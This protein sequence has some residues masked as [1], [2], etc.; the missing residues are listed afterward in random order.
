MSYPNH[1]TTWAA[2][3]A[4]VIGLALLPATTSAGQPQPE[5]GSAV[6]PGTTD[7]AA[8]PN[9]TLD[10]RVGYP[11]PCTDDLGVT[12]VVDFV[13]LGPHGASDGEPV[14]RCAPP[15]HAGQPFSGTGLDALLAAGI[16]PEG[17]KQNGLSFICRLEG[18][19]AADEALT[20]TGNPGYHEQCFRAPPVEAFWSYWW[21]AP[22]D[23]AWTS[24]NYGAT[25]R[26]AVPGGYEGWAFS[27]LRD[28][29]SVNPSPAVLPVTPGVVRVA[30]ADRYETAADLAG[31]TAAHPERV[32]VATGQ[33][34]PDALA[35][36]TVAGAQDVPVLLVRGDSV[37]DATRASLQALE[38]DEIVVLG[39]SSSVSDAVLADLDEL[40]PGAAVR[41][42]GP[43]RYATAT[44]LMTRYPIG[45]GDP[46]FVTTGADFPDVLAVSALA[47]HQQT[48]VLL[49][50]PTAL[51]ASARAALQAWGTRTGTVWGGPA[52][53]SD[54]VVGEL[55]DTTGGGWTRST[56]DDRYATAAAVAQRYQ[57]GVETV[58]VATGQGYPDALT[59]AAVAGSEG[60]PVLLTR[61]GSLP[62][63]T[64]AALERLDPKRIVVLGGENV[65]G[66]PVM[67]Q[68]EQYL[69]D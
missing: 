14:V 35:A 46:A 57:P 37:P 21:A 41:V 8:L 65:I 30:G 13:K 10:P 56:G 1:P 15:Q 5:H 4:A 18:R 33:D 64:A 2:T 3:G 31:R 63:A 32:F 45:T 20:L 7:A 43:N 27:Y 24:S 53:V 22:G 38:P 67:D 59:G 61:Q 29:P 58:Y 11:G 23:T 68:L 69:A 49:T 36:A 34:F 50:P 66:K 17:T 12:V 55:A 62:P 42:E 6:L 9:A 47:A 28:K 40:T 60:A 25:N 39:G 51:P 26:M 48:R 54:A 44:A 52:S 16:R 19:P